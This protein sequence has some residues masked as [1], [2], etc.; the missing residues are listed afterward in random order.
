LLGLFSSQGVLNGIHLLR[1][2]EVRLMRTCFTE[3]LNFRRSIGF[4]MQDEEALMGPLFS[5]SSFG[6]TGFTGTSVWIDPEQRL[7]IVV[8]TNRV[9]LGRE[10]TDAKLK[11]FRKK[12]IQPSAVIGAVPSN[13]RCNS[14]KGVTPIPGLAGGRMQPSR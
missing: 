10:P 5:R 9:H 11:A 3:G 12:S 2:E 7:E 14:R 8:L 1:P 4:R 6:H 13:N